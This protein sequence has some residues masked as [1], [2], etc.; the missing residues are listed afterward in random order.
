MLCVGIGINVNNGQMVDKPN[1]NEKSFNIMADTLIGKASDPYHEYGGPRL[2]LGCPYSQ[3][4]DV[5]S[6]LVWWLSDRYG[7]VRLHDGDPTI[8]KTA[9]GHADDK[10]FR[11]G[12]SYAE[13]NGSLHTEI[14]IWIGQDVQ[15]HAYTEVAKH[16]WYLYPSAKDMDE[17]NEDTVV[18]MDNAMDVINTHIAVAVAKAERL[19]AR[20][21]FM[22]DFCKEELHEKD[23]IKRQLKANPNDAGLKEQLQA[24]Q[25]ALDDKRAIAREDPAYK[26]LLIPGK[27]ESITTMFDLG[28]D[29]SEAVE[30]IGVEHNGLEK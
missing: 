23:R 8:N 5:C 16:G 19:E 11:Y 1:N 27:N 22:N 29:F 13:M 3:R 24:V 9:H 14:T 26:A 21:N 10:A 2:T 4:D 25:K 15:H 7:D 30:S 28:D 12:S 18:Y 20:K 6:H 17:R